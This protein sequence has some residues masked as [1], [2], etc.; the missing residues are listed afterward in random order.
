ML[1]T[2]DVIF[3]RPSITLKNSPTEE[4]SYVV[5]LM[6]FVAREVPA[7]A[8]YDTLDDYLDWKV[9]SNREAEKISNL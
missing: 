2:S 6:K 9:K 3:N 4:T 5:P 8:L 7:K 1:E